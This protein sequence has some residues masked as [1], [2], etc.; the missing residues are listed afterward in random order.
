MYPVPVHSGLSATGN[1]FIL[2]IYIMQHSVLTC[3]VFSKVKINMV[4]GMLLT[5]IIA[6]LSSKLLDQSGILNSVNSWNCRVI[7][8]TWFG[9]LVSLY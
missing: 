4:D 6:P 1:N 9:I 8:C 3:F 7:L 5:D 2:S